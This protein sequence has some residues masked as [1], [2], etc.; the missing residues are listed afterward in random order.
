MFFVEKFE[1]SDEPKEG[2]KK[3]P[4][5]LPSNRAITVLEYNLRCLLVILV[6]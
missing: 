5:T 2:N 4:V 1:N 3:S 6:Y